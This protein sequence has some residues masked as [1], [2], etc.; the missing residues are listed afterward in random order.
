MKIFLTGSGTGGHFYPNI[1]IAEQL[2]KI[3]KE[4]GILEMDL[5]FVSRE[6]Y[7]KTELERLGITH[8]FINS[9]KLRTYASIHT[10]FDIFRTISGIF[11]AFFL[12]FYIFPDVVFSKGGYTSFPVILAARVLRI[13]VFIHESDSVPGRVNKWAGKFAQKV[14]VSFPEAT[15]HFPEEKSVL[16]GRPMLEKISNI[17]DTR[18]AREFLHIHED[19]VPVLFILGGSQGAESINSTIINNLLN[20]AKEYY[21]IHQTG[22]AHIDVA[23]M[24]GMNLLKNTGFEHRYK[25]YD[26]L[27]TKGMRRAA[28]LADVVVSRA[29]STLFEI[30][31]WGKASILIPYEYAHGQHQHHNAFAYAR[32]GACH[33]IEEGNLSAQVLLM[34][35][36]SILTDPDKKKTMEKAAKDFHKPEAAKMIAKELTEI[37]LSHE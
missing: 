16:S 30:A 2:R 36:E 6:S 21:I 25:P 23:K 14:F 5:Y 11:K 12:M 7:D 17:E 1:A 27:N 22:K 9:G 37:G 24:A 15:S 35:I 28:T 29:G 18:G 31:A 8:K 3:Q 10:F 20:F 34:E 33:V 32:A 13:P 19:D 26:F 4:E